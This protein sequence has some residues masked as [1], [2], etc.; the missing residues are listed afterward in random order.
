MRS[1]NPMSAILDHCSRSVHK[2]KFMHAR[3]YLRNASFK[4]T[5]RPKQCETRKMCYKWLIKL[6]CNYPNI[7]LC[8][9]HT[10]KHSQNFNLNNLMQLV[11]RTSG[12]SPSVCPLCGRPH[13]S[14]RTQTAY[15]PYGAETQKQ[16]CTVQIARQP[17]FYTLL[18]AS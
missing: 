1:R 10:Q 16:S 15:S 11:P 5:I 17:F 8:D 9:C 18:E 14:D 13:R 2:F 12:T 7:T 3:D 6:L 4:F